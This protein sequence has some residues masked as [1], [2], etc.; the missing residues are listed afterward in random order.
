MSLG[1]LSGIISDGP[2]SDSFTV[3]FPLDGVDPGPSNG[4]FPTDPFLVNGPTVNRDLLAQLFQPGSTV[5][6]GGSFS[7]DN[8]DRTTPYARQASLGVERQVGSTMSA[9]AEYIHVAN[10]NAFLNR[11][12]NPGLRTSTSRTARYVRI[13]DEFPAGVFT[14]V[15]E[16]ETDYDALQLAFEK[17]FSNNWSSRVSYTLSRG[18]GNFDGNGIGTSPFQL[19]D[20]LQLEL[21]EG[22]VDG[23]RTHNLVVSGSALVPH[24]GGLT[25]SW[26]ARALSGSTFTLVDSR[27]D[28]DRNGTFSEPLEAGTYSG[29]GED[30][31]TVDFERERNGARGPGFFQ[32][33]IRAGYRFHLGGDT[34]VDA[35]GEIFNATNRT[36]FSNP[37]GDLRSSNFLRLTGLRDGAL[38]RTGQI[39][40]RFAF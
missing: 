30:A 20:D 12:L 19:L 26:V 8:P 39:G 14:L 40:L 16:G 21:N 9:S 24:T 11:D 4:Q 37:S 29:E 34:T 13:S 35:F 17:R 6:N 22:P 2:L 27:T 15:N 31:Y 5:P 18:R 10:R 3:N 28:P 36:N 33:D 32:L 25:V 38:T 7:I 1:T 23:D